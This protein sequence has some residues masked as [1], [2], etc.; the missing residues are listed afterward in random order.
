M[1]VDPTLIPIVTAACKLNT[2]T[3]EGESPRYRHN[4]SITLVDSKKNSKNLTA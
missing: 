4:D 2:I 1:L 3:G